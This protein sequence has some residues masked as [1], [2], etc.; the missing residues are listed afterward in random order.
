MCGGPRSL[1]PA[2]WGLVGSLWECGWP[3]CPG[4]GQAECGRDE[5]SEAVG[6]PR[7]P[8]LLA[9]GAWRVAFP[10]RSSAQG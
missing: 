8:L 1:F 6:R 10:L 7:A 3:G 2:T 9:E 4:A 5:R